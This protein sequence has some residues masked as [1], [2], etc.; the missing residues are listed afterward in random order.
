MSHED[1]LWMYLNTILK[2]IKCLFC[3]EWIW[4]VASSNAICKVWNLRQRNGGTACNMLGWNH[5]LLVKHRACLVLPVTVTYSAAV[6]FLKIPYFVLL[7]LRQCMLWIYPEWN[8]QVVH[9]NVVWQSHHHQ[10][11]EN[12]RYYLQRRTRPAWE[13]CDFNQSLSSPRSTCC[14]L[15]PMNK[16]K[17]VQPTSPSPQ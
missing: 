11:V 9:P 7:H 1:S 13:W 15:E 2:C 5:G 10:L 12:A 14:D 6:S 17:T 8:R 16:W 4:T 3:T